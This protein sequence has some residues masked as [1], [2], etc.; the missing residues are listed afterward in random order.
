[1][2]ML[3]IEALAAILALVAAVR[4]NALN[5]MRRTPKAFLLRL[6][7]RLLLSAAVA[8]ILGGVAMY[9]YFYSYCWFGGTDCA[10]YSQCEGG[11]PFS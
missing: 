1:M 5:S 6:L 4:I 8:V 9:L 7:L 2:K 10:H 11:F 3:L